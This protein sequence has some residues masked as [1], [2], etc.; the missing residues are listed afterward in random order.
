M[1]APVVEL[2]ADVVV[3][4]VHLHLIQPC[5]FNP[6]RTLDPLKQR[7]L[8]ESIRQFGIQ[9]PLLGRPTADGSGVELVAGFRR[10]CAA[11]VLRLETVPCIVRPMTDAEARELALVDNLQREDVP[12]LEEADA[13]EA[14]RQQMGGVQAVARRVGKPVDHVAKRLRLVTLG[15]HTRRALAERLI[16]IDHALLLARLGT[17]EEDAALKWCLDNQAGSKTTVEKVVEACV[18]RRDRA[19][20]PWHGYSEPK[21]VLQLKARIEQTS[22]RKLSRAPW[23]LDDAHLVP[24]VGTCAGCPSNT[25]ANDLLFGDLNIA[26]ATCSDG[27]CFEA[28]RAQFVHLAVS[29]AGGEKTVARLSWNEGSVRP[30]MTVGRAVEG[31]KSLNSFVATADLA[32]VLKH[33]QWVEAKLGSCPDVIQGVTVNWLEAYGKKERKP[34]ETLTVCVVEGCKA[35]P[36]SY[37]RKSEGAGSKALDEKAEKARR[38]ANKAK[39]VEENKKR[40]AVISAQSTARIK[41]KPTD[42]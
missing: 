10:Y 6:R 8:E 33:G 26:E 18:G 24:G 17:E 9:T 36:K 4:S 3:E 1:T 2:P 5:P 7:D 12:A 27:I 41:T 28:K 30:K 13:Y 21:T 40:M 22:G 25:A 14:L 37:E 35:H 38:E 31:P 20:D 11:G 42:P 16:T 39:E 34:G 15:T 29:A 19:R 32:K 23:S